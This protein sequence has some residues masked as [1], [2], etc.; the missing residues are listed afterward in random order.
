MEEPVSI[1]IECDGTLTFHIL[2]K[3]SETCQIFSENKLNE[4]LLILKLD[5]LS[6][7]GNHVFC[8]GIMLKTGV[9][10]F[11]KPPNLV[12]LN[13]PSDRYQSAKCLMYYKVDKLSKN[14]KV[15]Q[16]KECALISSY[17]T[18]VRKRKLLES[19][20]QRFKRQSITSNYGIT[21]LTPRSKNIR[22]SR[23]QNARKTLANKVAKLRESS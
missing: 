16:C 9:E 10:E 20:N 6:S 12:F 13:Y 2:F 19:P 15:K 23:L 17:C 14:T 18:K 5:K 8:S 7:V 11:V 21:N 1:T 4:D 3:S 22:I